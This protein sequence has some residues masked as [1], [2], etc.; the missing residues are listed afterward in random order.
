MKI[1]IAEDD[2]Y[3]RKYLEDLL[4]LEKYECLTAKNGE[5]ALEI[6]KKN[7]IDVI[8]TDIQM[9]RLSG[10]ELLEEVRKERSD[11]LIIMTTAYGSE[12]FAIRALQLGANNYLKKPINVEQL[13]Q[14]LAKYQKLLSHPRINVEELGKIEYKHL[15]IV[16][17]NKFE[18]ISNIVQ[19]LMHEIDVKFDDAE[20]INIELGL[21]ELITNAVEHG[22]LEISYYQKQEALNNNELEKLYEQRANDSRYANRYIKVEYLFN[23][24]YCQ[25]TIQDQ[26]R[27]FDYNSLPDP[28]K[29]NLLELNGRGIFISR[30]LFDEL[31]Y[32]GCGNC[33]KIRKYYKH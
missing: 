22:N 7:K 15:K 20:K 24:G 5:E 26:G 10:L 32:L 29:D 9:P 30:F 25:W 4:R 18:N 33:V 31:T 2:L 8:I 11:V 17:E 14:L 27:G 1:L 28:T 21:L 23:D 12:E 16:F 6:Y 19:Q 3:S 13:L